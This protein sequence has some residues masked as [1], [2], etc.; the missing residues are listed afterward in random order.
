VSEHFFTQNCCTLSDEEVKDLVQRYQSGDN[1]AALPLLRSQGY[2]VMGLVSKYNIPPS[3]SLDD[4]YSELTV[5]FLASLAIYNT[6]ESKLSTFFKLILWRRMPLILSRL[7]D[8][9][10]NVED[11]TVNPIGGEENFHGI[12]D[13]ESLGVICD[14]MHTNLTAFERHVLVDYIHDLHYD[15]IT[16]RANQFVRER[17]PAAPEVSEYAIRNH[18]QRAVQTIREE[19]QR[20]GDIESTGLLIM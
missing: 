1:E 5:E 8:E 4:I 15:A 12:E 6:D 2:W 16:E 10:S 9:A 13:D 3:V 14:I 11:G 18:I 17:D 20:R 7:M 19:M